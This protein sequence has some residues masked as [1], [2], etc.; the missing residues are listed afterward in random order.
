MPVMTFSDPTLKKV[1]KGPM[2]HAFLRDDLINM[3]RTCLTAA[4]RSNRSA[5]YMDG[6]CDVLSLLAVQLGL[7]YDDN[8]IG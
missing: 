5:E 4:E 3:L 8:R 2:S 1:G 6:T 7:E